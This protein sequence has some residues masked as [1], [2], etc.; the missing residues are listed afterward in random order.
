MKQDLTE[1]PVLV[2]PDPATLFILDTDASGTGIGG[3]LSQKVPEEEER[4]IAY[5]S[6][7]LSAQERRY[8]VTRRELLAVALPCL[9]PGQCSVVKLY[10]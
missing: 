8:C 5:F 6:R 2:Y 7:P 3:V 9:A 1:A 4:V 10:C